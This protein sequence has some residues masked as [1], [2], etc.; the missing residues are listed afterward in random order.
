ME[1]EEYFHQIQKEKPMI[2]K[3][4]TVNFSITQDNSDLADFP[5]QYISQT[6]QYADVTWVKVLEDV[7][8]VLEVNYGYD[9]KSKVYYVVHNPV[10]DHNYSDAPG[11]ELD[12]KLFMKVLEENPELNNG[13]KHKPFDL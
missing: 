11:R 2:K 9:I 5:D 1:L 7:I 3:D 4:T 6:M 10:F 13:G 8:K 12:S